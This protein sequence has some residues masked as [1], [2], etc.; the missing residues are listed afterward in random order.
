LN[1]AVAMRDVFRGELRFGDRFREAKL[2]ELTD[3]ALF[4]WL[5]KALDDELA[6]ADRMSLAVH[7]FAA[8]LLTF[9]DKSIIDLVVSTSP[10]VTGPTGGAVAYGSNVLSLLL[11]L[12]AELQ[13]RGREVIDRPAV[14]AWLEQHGERLLW[15]ADAGK[16]VLTSPR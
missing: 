14:R 1:P 4:L 5:R 10:E 15:N 2:A 8:A 7:M 9:G 3:D 6:K 12:P 13:R 16:F 11:P